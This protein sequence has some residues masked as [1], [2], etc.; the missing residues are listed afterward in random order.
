MSIPNVE[1]ITEIIKEIFEHVK[2]IEVNGD[3]VSFIAPSVDGGHVAEL[4]KKIN[5]AFMWTVSSWDNRFVFMQME[6]SI[7]PHKDTLDHH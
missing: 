1:H 3:F 2:E 6:L 7:P 4:Y 5:I